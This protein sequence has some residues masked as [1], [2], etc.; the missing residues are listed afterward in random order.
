MIIIDS[1]DLKDL[2]YIDYNKDT[3]YETISM[4]IEDLSKENLLYNLYKAF[5]IDKIYT[6]RE[7]RQGL[8]E[9]YSRDNKVIKE[10]IDELLDIYNVDIPYIEIVK[11][12]IHIKGLSDTYIKLS[13][14][15]ISMFEG[16]ELGDRISDLYEIMDTLDYNDKHKY[17]DGYSL[18]IA[19]HTSINHF[20]SIDNLSKICIKEKIPYRHKHE[21]TSIRI[22]NRKLRVEFDLILKYNKRDY[23]VE[24][25]VGTTSK[26]DMF[27]KLYKHNLL[28]INNNIHKR[29]IF[30]APN[31][32]SLDIVKAKV[33]NTIKEYNKKRLFDS[34]L[35]PFI[36]KYIYLNI[37]SINN[38][39]SLRL[40]M[41]RNQR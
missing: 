18:A 13:D 17:L 2:D 7:L 31:K 24:V 1:K 38:K 41:S 8:R 39:H 11:P 14:L 3:S 6:I 5:Y 33:N 12:D 9:G 20:S 34:S 4:V 26:Q 16:N 19:Q 23:G 35:E 37:S 40:F 32:E 22:N 29:V 27:K 30:A 10:A 21:D 25:E 36:V 28:A 15:A